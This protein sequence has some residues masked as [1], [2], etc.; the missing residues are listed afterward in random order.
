MTVGLKTDIKAIL[1][2]LYVM[3]FLEINLRAT[4]KKAKDDSQGKPNRRKET[5]NL[6]LTS[7]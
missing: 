4:F 5:E 6:F 1:Y 2:L 7:N 3:R